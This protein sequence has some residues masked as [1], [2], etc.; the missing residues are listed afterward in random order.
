MSIR[1]YFIIGDL[2]SNL[3]T[4]AVVGLACAGVFDTGWPPLIAMIAGMGLGTT[5]AVVLGL[6]GFSRYFG[7]LETMVPV[8]LTGMLTGMVVSMAAAMKPIGYVAGG[9][10]GVLIGLAAL[11]A[12]Y[13]VNF[14]LNGELTS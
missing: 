11:A 4:G 2:V 8:M 3:A 13:I 7:A 9:A 10:L 14:R 6:F 12:T 1:P 5:L